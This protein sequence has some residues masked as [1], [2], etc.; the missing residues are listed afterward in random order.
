MK[1]I[2]VLLVNLGTP[3]APTRGA[4]KKYLKEFLLDPRVI[5]L[6]WLKRQLLVRGLIIPFRLNQSLKSY[7]SIWTKEGSPLLVH[8]KNARDLLQM[9][10]EGKFHV[11]LAMRYQSP[12]IHEGLKRLMDKNIKELLILPLFPQ[13]ASATTGSIFEKVFQE[14]ASFQSLPKLTFINQFCTHPSLIQAFK[15]AAAPFNLMDYDH[16]LFSFHGL[17]QRQLKK[18]NPRCC[19]PGCCEKIQNCYASECRQTAHAIADACQLN[20][21]HFS[22]CFQS[23]LGK[24]P[25]IEPFTSDRIEELAKKGAK[26]ILV[27]CPA[28]VADCLETLFEIGVEYQELFIHHG[29]QKLDLVPGLN[30][31]PAWIDA[32][33]TL[34]RENTGKP[35]SM[36][37]LNL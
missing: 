11:E 19:Q 15:T 36:K 5:D 26:K 25:W 16:I 7:Q 29:G 10:L 27:F 2:G 13:Y 12:S 9:R 4:L 33:E 6:P 8:S 32:L 23:R 18:N 20:H 3:D 30:A 22:I 31:E 21:S 28:F 24:D 37:A 1:L 35:A 14:L 17:P 34:V